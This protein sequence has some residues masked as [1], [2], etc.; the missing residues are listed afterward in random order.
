MKTSLHKRSY[1]SFSEMSLK[2]RNNSKKKKNESVNSSPSISIFNCQNSMNKRPETSLLTNLKTVNFFKGKNK[3]LN[4]L[5]LII[6]SNP[7]KINKNK[8]KKKIKEINPLFSKVNS[9]NNINNN[10]MTKYDKKTEEKLYKYNILYGSYS[11]NIIRTYSPKMRPISSSINSFEKKINSKESIENNFFSEKEI[12][13]LIEAKCKD[14]G[15]N[16]RENMINK[17]RDYCNLKCKNRKIIL[18]ECNL[19]FYSIKFL[20]SIII[21]E[22]R[23]S[24][25]NLSK[26]NIGNKG[27]ILLSNAIRKN[28]SLVS[29]N[30]TS[31]CITSKGGEHLL[32]SLINQ[33]S[34]IEFNINSCEGINRNRISFL[35][36]KNIEKVL[37]YNLFLENFCVSGNGIKNE[38][39]IFIFNGLNTNQ[40]LHYLDVSNNDI[41]LNG[42]ENTFCK[43]NICKLIELNISDNFFGD[44]GLIKITESLKNF[45]QITTL[46]IS[47]CGIEFKGF[48]YLLKNIILLKRIKNLDISG[49]NI[50]SKKFNLIKQYFMNLNIINLNLSNCSLGNKAGKILGEC[51]NLNE[52]IEKIYLSNNKISDEGFKSF[53]PLFKNNYSIKLFDISRNFISE[54]STF[55]FIE[56]L[57]ENKT[58][59]KINF[60]DNQLKSEI[61]NL[62]LEIL[63]INKTLIK[64][65]LGYNRIPLKFIEEINKKLKENEENLKNNFV[66]KLERQV[67][68]Q[69]FS[70]VLFR[71]FTKKIIDRK[72]F[73]NQISEKIIQDQINYKNLRKEESNNLNLLI[74]KN[75]SLEKE[76]S[77]VEFKN[78][79]LSEQIKKYKENYYIKLFDLEKKIDKIKEELKLLEEKNKKLNFECEKNKMELE[80]I[81]KQTE[82]QVKLSKEK[83]QL[84][85]ISLN[86]LQKDLQ[87]KS[88]LYNQINKR[89]SI[90]S[91]KR[92]SMLFSPK[93]IRRSLNNNLG[94]KFSENKLIKE[95]KNNIKD[96]NINNNKDN[97]NDIINNKINEN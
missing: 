50:K 31:N 33:Q 91:N 15:I 83:V 7:I 89:N 58:L 46:K 70:P 21:K 61:G 32:N 22:D 27:A 37:F 74:D 5:N 62:L 14:I 19:G 77:E 35:G 90:F 23:I 26:N 11:N 73:Q 47:N 52:T 29:L 49:N 42:I 85:N 13:L 81:I 43:I 57:K 51:L 1:S 12:K 95:D 93:K 20:C 87:I 94:R 34:L 82:V 78:K 55:K 92:K 60:F 38:G 65:D 8:L 68:T 53:I 59:K 86:N 28:N 17:F 6:E 10:N 54:K 97:N 48:Y 71:I 75:K 63:S 24:I 72:N 16:L 44:E 41:N 64:I 88:D 36:I 2:K 3:E 25:L 4:L 76:I 66:P 56:N 30:L 18:N 79:L 9:V 40:T 96:N 84:A 80:N 39:L 45:P 69:R 67:Q